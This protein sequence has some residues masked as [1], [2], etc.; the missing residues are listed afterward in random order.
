MANDSRRM[1][2]DIDVAFIGPN[3]TGPTTFKVKISF[4]GGASWGRE[5]LSLTRVACALVCG[6][7]AAEAGV[8]GQVNVLCLNKT[9]P[10]CWYGELENEVRICVLIV[11]TRDR[12]DL[13]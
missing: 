7:I 4:I 6:A 9:P 3:N 1:A 2:I 10:S 8:A 11:T 5:G 13:L 12:A